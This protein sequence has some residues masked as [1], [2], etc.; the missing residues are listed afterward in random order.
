MIVLADLAPFIALAIVL[1]FVIALLASAVRVLRE[2]QR[3]V[4]LG[5]VAEHH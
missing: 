4:L 1:V 3:G 2:Y 5:G